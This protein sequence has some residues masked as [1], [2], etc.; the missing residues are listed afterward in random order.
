MCIPYIAVARALIAQGHRAVI[1]TSEDHRTVIE[2]AGVEFCAMY[3]VM[4]QKEDYQNVVARLF[5]VRRGPKELVCR[6]VMPHLRPAF[7][8]LLE[9]SKGADVLVSHPLAMALPLVAEKLG[10]PRVATVLSPMLFV[11]P[12]DPP[13]IPDALWLNRLRMFGPGPYRF[14]FN[15]AKRMI[16][17]WERPLHDLRKELGL[18]PLRHSALLEGHYS[19]LLNLALFDPQLAK[20]QPDWPANTLICGSPVF[21]GAPS[22]PAALNDLEQFLADGEAP[23]VFA[24]GSSA[25][26]IAGDFWDKAVAAVRG[27]WTARDFTDRASRAGIAARNCAGLFRTCRIQRC[28]RTRLLSCI[29]QASAHWRRQCA[30]DARSS[31]CPWHSTSPTMPGVPAHLD[32]REPCPSGR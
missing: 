12:Y 26:W 2:S 14:L 11:S 1:A 3:P 4:A 30:P 17:S 31:L 25:V 7:E 28:F 13:V 19:P 23:I 10:I 22:D 18:A 8:I 20:P 16:K 24:L 21:D 32:L 5:D 9:A 29:R 27:A 6:I 15:M